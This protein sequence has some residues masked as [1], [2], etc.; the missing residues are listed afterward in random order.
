MVQDVHKMLCHFLRKQMS[1]YFGTTVFVYM[2]NIGTESKSVIFACIVL[3]NF[4]PQN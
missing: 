1:L 3:V 2:K 4:H